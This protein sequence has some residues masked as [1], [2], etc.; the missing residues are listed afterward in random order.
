M[1]GMIVLAP[2]W[3][4]WNLGKLIRSALGFSDQDLLTCLRTLHY[5]LSLSARMPVT[6]QSSMETVWRDW[7][8]PVCSA[9]VLDVLLPKHSIFNSLLL[10]FTCFPAPAFIQALFWMFAGYVDILYLDDEYRRSFLRFSAFMGAIFARRMLL[11]FWRF[12][13]ML[14]SYVWKYATVFSTFCLCFGTSW[15]FASAVRR[16]RIKDLWSWIG[17]WAILGPT[18]LV[19]G[20]TVIIALVLRTIE[21]GIRTITSVLSLS[22]PSF[23]YSSAAEFDPRSQI[24]LLKLHRKIPFL[25]LS[26]ELVSHTIQDAP[27]YHAI[28]YVWNYGPQ[29]IRTITLSG[30]R[31]EI[32][33]NVHDILTRCSSFFLPRLIWIDSICIDQASDSEK[34]LQVRTMREIYGT[35]AHVLVCLGEGPAFLAFTLLQELK[36]V[37]DV[38]GEAEV[39]AYVSLLFERQ[40]IDMYLR[41]RVRALQNLLQHPWF[42]RV[43][44]IQEVVVARQVTIYYGRHSFDWLEFYNL[45]RIIS[46]PVFCFLCQSGSAPGLQEMAPSYIGNLSMSFIV[47]YRIEYQYLEP[48]R[49]CHLL[50][51]FGVRDSTYPLDKVFALI[52]MAKY[53]STDLKQLV[54]YDQEK[55]VVLHTLANFLLDNGEALEVLD[56]AGIG[57]RGHDPSLPSWAVDWT[58]KRAGMPLDSTFA[59]SM[60]RYNATLGKRAS[61]V[62]GNSRQEMVVKGQLVDYIHS[63]VPIIDAGATTSPPFDNIIEAQMSYHNEALNLA[64]RDV[65]DPYPYLENQPLEEAVWRTIIGDKTNSERPAPALYGRSLRTAFQHIQDMMQISSLY[66]PNMMFTSSAM[67][68]LRTEWGAGKLLELPK[69]LEDF[70]SIDLLYDSGK[71]SS[72]HVFCTT[73]K[74]Y[75]CMVPPMSKVGDSICLIYG[76]W[77]P[78]VLRASVEDPKRYQLVGD[79]YVHG[80]MDGE[81][82]ELSYPDD[83][84]TLV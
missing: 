7:I 70:Q 64:Q 32:K 47:A 27:P 51:V 26:G 22:Q 75:M 44:V 78:F 31:L 18:N 77:V 19:Y 46:G 24:R 40:R 29:D 58:W 36:W 13:K 49:I 38:Y 15:L 53:Y 6:F 28:S 52:G 41:A 3:W 48:Q 72:P 68:N 60:L 33:S 61:V 21:A 37:R 76:V 25:E 39:P 79:S 14:I 65:K 80:I 74:G 66:A 56:M 43:W 69:S 63:L 35:A 83:D 59:S 17:L 34:T 23:S 73:K 20:F 5:V 30:M 82:L 81:A 9:M 50:R 54:D 42:N 2:Q 12:P 1:I 67:E 84:F 8:F 71:F 55:G 45:L 16:R 4:R 62:R 11:P 10:I 57:W